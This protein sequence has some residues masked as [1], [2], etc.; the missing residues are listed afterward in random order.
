MF[1]DFLKE[2]LNFTSFSDVTGKSEDRNPVFFQQVLGLFK[3]FLVASCN[4]ELAACPAQ[5]SCYGQPNAAIPTRDN[6]RFVFKSIQSSTR[7]ERK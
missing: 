7:E 3:P 5:E 2:L 1:F 6:S 4:Y